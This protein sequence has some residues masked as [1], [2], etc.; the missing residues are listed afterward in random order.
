MHF[1]TALQ[2]GAKAAR[3]AIDCIGSIGKAV[4]VGVLSLENIDKTKS[5]LQS[6]GVKA[7]EL[8]FIICNAGSDVFLRS[9]DRMQRSS[10]WSR[11]ASFRWDADIVKKAIFRAADRRHCVTAP[12]RPQWSANEELQEILESVRT[13]YFDLTFG[14]HKSLANVCETS[15]MLLLCIYRTGT[16][17]CETCKSSFCTDE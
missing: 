10:E 3:S 2:S 8:D 4:A 15:V 9:G 14:V 16:S 17:K 7:N 6:G 12:Q 1:P 13:L 11:K 5:T